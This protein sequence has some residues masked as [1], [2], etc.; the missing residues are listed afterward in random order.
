MA[1]EQSTKSDS[2]SIQS[3]RP[4]NVVLGQRASY[5]PADKET[6][7][8]SIP[9][10]IIEALE[11]ARF[12]AKKALPKNKK[13]K[14]S[15]SMLYGLALEALAENYISR[16]EESALWKLIFDWADD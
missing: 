11:E 3:T 9:S 6:I 4:I 2:E 15:R 13:K 1:F 8:I 5:L 12:E 10:E 7:T 14:L 16:R